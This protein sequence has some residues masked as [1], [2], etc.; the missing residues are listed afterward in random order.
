MTPSLKTKMAIV[1]KSDNFLIGDTSSFMAV[2]SIGILI[3]GRVILT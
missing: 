2:F 1:G 3:F